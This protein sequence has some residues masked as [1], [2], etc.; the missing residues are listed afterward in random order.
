VEETKPDKSPAACT[1]P[2]T[3]SPATA[4]SR[5]HPDAAVVAKVAKK[6]KKSKSTS[7]ASVPA[8]DSDPLRKGPRPKDWAAGPRRK[9]AAKLKRKSLA[10]TKE[11]PQPATA[12][13]MATGTAKA[14]TASNGER[15]QKSK[16]AAGKR[17]DRGDSGPAAAAS[18]DRKLLGPAKKKATVAKSRSKGKGKKQRAVALVPA[19]SNPTRTFAPAVANGGDDKKVEGTGTKKWNGIG[20]LKCLPF[21]PF[22][23]SANFVPPPPPKKL[24]KGTSPFSKGHLHSSRRRR[25]LAKTDKKTKGG[26]RVMK[27]GIA[28][29]S[30]KGGKKTDGNRPKTISVGKA[31]SIVGP[32]AGTSGSCMRVSIF[33]PSANTIASGEVPGTDTCPPSRPPKT[34][35]RLYAQN[36]QAPI[37]EE[38]RKLEAEAAKKKR[39]LKKAK[40]ASRGR[41]EEVLTIAPLVLRS[42]TVRGRPRQRVQTM[43]HRHIVGGDFEQAWRRIWSHSAELVTQDSHAMTPCDYAITFDAPQELLEAMLRAQCPLGTD[44]YTVQ[45]PVFNKNGRTQ[46]IESVLHPASDQ[47]TTLPY[48]YNDLGQLTIHRA[49]RNNCAIRLQKMLLHY[50]PE[51]AICEVLT[52]GFIKRLDRQREFAEDGEYSTLTFWSRSAST[53]FVDRTDPKH[54]KAN[55]SS[56]P[57]CSRKHVRSAN[58]ITSNLFDLAWNSKLERAVMGRRVFLDERMDTAEKCNDKN[59]ADGDRIAI[60][61]MWSR[62]SVLL[63]TTYDTYFGPNALY[64]YGELKRKPVSEIE[65]F[66]DLAPNVD[67]YSPM[68][69]KTPGPNLESEIKPFERPDMPPPPH[70][71]SSGSIVPE[72]VPF[73][74]N[75]QPPDEMVVA[76]SHPA[77]VTALLHHDIALEVIIFIL[78]LFPEQCKVQDPNSGLFPIHVVAKGLC[79]P[80]R[81]AWK[82]PTSKDKGDDSNIKLTKANHIRNERARSTPLIPLLLK[83]CPESADLRDSCGRLPVHYALECGHRYLR[84]VHKDLSSGEQ[85]KDSDESKEDNT[86]KGYYDT[87]LKE[88]LD[89]SP[90]VHV[91][92]DPKTGLYPFMLAASSPGNNLADLT[93]VYELL[94]SNPDPVQSGIFK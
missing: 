46:S 44:A 84:A 32:I 76:P 40:S 81:W 82:L 31:V 16:A 17:K 65:L 6:R 8:K 93:T 71:L 92:P 54:W 63:K 23:F 87:G 64:Q 5:P 22:I 59:L 61:L 29:I 57:R 20:E 55:A 37:A 15:S 27:A 53:T 67:V 7:S 78:R 21:K 83:A 28:T 49:F 74:Y 30:K 80:F 72:P 2:A 14:R 85:E 45:H 94:R 70:V 39:K 42:P 43:M 60:G 24:A 11:R 91:H 89:A 33:D 58:E 38:A 34:V 13:A 19:S 73:V 47:D 3:K 18:Q 9:I 88:L 77:L 25:G 66:P 36:L 35:P 51:L 62:F 26:R 4:K 12:A 75:P 90:S 1:P 86:S 41:S 68:A 50:N 79:P 56:G 69:K 48:L 52:A 10:T